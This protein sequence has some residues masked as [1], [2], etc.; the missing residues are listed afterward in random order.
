M[1]PSVWRGA[2]QRRTG[3]GAGAGHHSPPIPRNTDT[4]Q[5]LQHHHSCS[6]D[7]A[8]RAEDLLLVRGAAAA[9]QRDPAHQLHH[10]VDPLQ[11]TVQPGEGGTRVGEAS[12][13][14]HFFLFKQV[15]ICTFN[16][17]RGLSSI[18]SFSMFP[19]VAVQF[20]LIIMF[21]F[22]HVPGRSWCCQFS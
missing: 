9:V 5:H 19:I 21:H 15:K 22:F 7:G 13:M 18:Y 17:S 12:R 1:P 3:A 10:P 11:H 16:T 2:A 20:V 8:G 6:G 4:D 14:E